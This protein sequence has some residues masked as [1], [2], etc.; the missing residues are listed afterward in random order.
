MLDATPIKI[1]TWDALKSKV[2]A[3]PPEY[4]EFSGVALDLMRQ[5][6]TRTDSSKR[7]M[8]RQVATINACGDSVLVADSV[9]H[10][11]KAGAEA[12]ILIGRNL[13]A[14]REAS[15][16]GCLVL[17]MPSAAA[18]LFFDGCTPFCEQGLKT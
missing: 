6:K 10:L 12:I 5:A 7:N 13:E 4:Q 8:L 11:I 1:S 3:A 16:A 2:E 14:E 15:K 9:R 18:P 17:S